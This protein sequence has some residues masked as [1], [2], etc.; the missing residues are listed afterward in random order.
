MA[1]TNYFWDEEDDNVLAEYDDGGTITASYVNE[2]G[3]YGKLLSE[4]RSGTDRNYHYDVQ[5]NTT[6]LTA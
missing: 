3:Q 2:P 6:K 5:G 1:V 4:D